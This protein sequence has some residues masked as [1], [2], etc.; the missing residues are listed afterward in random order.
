MGGL[1]FRP[2]LRLEEEKQQPEEGRRPQQREEPSPKPRQFGGV[3]AVHRPHEQQDDQADAERQDPVGVVLDAA[4]LEFAVQRALG[5]E[6]RRRRKSWAPPATRARPGNG[7][8]RGAGR[9]W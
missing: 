3:A 7:R 4:Q 1:E 2:P 6:Q 5:Q 9:G 8:R